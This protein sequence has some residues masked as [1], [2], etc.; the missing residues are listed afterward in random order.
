[1]PFFVYILKSEISGSSYVGYTS[2]ITKRLLEHNSGKSIST[3]SKKPW[4]LV[5]QEEFQVPEYVN[6]FETLLVRI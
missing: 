4:R 2:D 1:M 3:R 5:Y 6:D